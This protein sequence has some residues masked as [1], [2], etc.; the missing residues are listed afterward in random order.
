[1]DFD[2]LSNFYNIK[3]GIKNN[4]SYIIYNK[5]EIYEFYTKKRNCYLGEYYC[6]NEDYMFICGFKNG[7]SY[8]I[9]A[10]DI[11]NKNIISAEDKLNEI[12]NQY[13]NQKRKILT[14]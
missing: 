10:F 2:E 14:K 6:G 9:R 8:A 12:Y 7:E 1:M 11:K 4:T 5:V 3:F 13:K